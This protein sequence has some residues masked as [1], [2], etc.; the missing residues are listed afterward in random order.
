MPSVREWPVRVALALQ[1]SLANF[2]AGLFI[3]LAGQTRGDPGPR[4]AEDELR[5]LTARRSLSIIVGQSLLRPAR[6]PSVAA[7]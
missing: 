4:S 1:E 5:S 3:T 7:A 2:F 6:R